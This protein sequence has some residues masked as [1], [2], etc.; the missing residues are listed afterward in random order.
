MNITDSTATYD[1]WLQRQLPG[2]VVE[3]DLRKKHARMRSGRFVFL[4]ATYWR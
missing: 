4:R 1:A 2:E 3:A